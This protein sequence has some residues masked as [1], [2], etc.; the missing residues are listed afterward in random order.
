VSFSV[1]VADIAVV[2]AVVV[3][4]VVDCVDHLNDDC[5]VV[6]CCAV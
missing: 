3:V 6:C 4:V 5:R 1:V 2:V